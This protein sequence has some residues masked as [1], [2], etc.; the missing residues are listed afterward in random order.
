M[1]AYWLG[2]FA[3]A[4]VQALIEGTVPESVK[5][6]ATLVLAPVTRT[7]QGVTTSVYRSKRRPTE[8][9][10]AYVARVEHQ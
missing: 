6:C 2:P 5:Q 3:E 1:T 7:D 4:E 8:A 9:D 10:A